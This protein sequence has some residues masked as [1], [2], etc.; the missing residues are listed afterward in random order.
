MSV[1]EFAIFSI[2]PPY[3]AS[4]P[5]LLAQLKTAIQVLTAASDP[6][7]LYLIGHWDSIAHHER[8]LVS[9]E[10]QQLLEN[11]KDLF[12]V[13]AMFHV[14]VTKST[15]PLS[16]PILTVA[17]HYIK[18]EDKDK[19]SALWLEVSSSLAEFTNPF[20]LVGGWRIDGLPE[21]MEEWDQWSGFNTVE[22]HHDF[23]NSEGFKKYGGIKEYLSGF[24][25]KH[26]S[27]LKLE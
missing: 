10:N 11:T 15:L 23:G 1:T 3:T 27:E 17:R 5:T 25:V 2:K 6:S 13:D 14:P 19:F 21:A 18:S 20:P 24:E 7:I 4:S 22:E 12:T 9:Q 26:A 8:F 16:A